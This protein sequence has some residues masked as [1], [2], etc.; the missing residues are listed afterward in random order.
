MRLMDGWKRVWVTRTPRAREWTD[1]SVNYTHP[2]T[3][4]GRRLDL[5]T[6]VQILNVFNTFAIVNPASIDVGVLDPV[7]ASAR[8]QRFNPFTTTPVEGVNWARS[9][10]FGQPFA[11]SAYNIGRT[12]SMSFGVRF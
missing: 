5:F 6:Q 11:A 7:L 8:F 4:A 2:V 1:A 9:P 10:T 3:L 12:F